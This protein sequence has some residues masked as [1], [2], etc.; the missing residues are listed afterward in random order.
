MFIL[1]D[2][3][4]IIIIVIIIKNNESYEDTKY[5]IQISWKYILTIKLQNTAQG[6]FVGGFWRRGVL[7]LYP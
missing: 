6:S 2:L 4:I 7:C 3:S 5:I 1:N